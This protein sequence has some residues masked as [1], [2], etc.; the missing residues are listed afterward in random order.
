MLSGNAAPV[1]GGSA[2]AR[3]VSAVK[4]SPK[5]KLA[6]LGDKSKGFHTPDPMLRYGK[7]EPRVCHTSRST[8]VCVTS[9]HSI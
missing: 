4:A 6:S 5:F 3:D 1:T 9:R 7:G 8:T 2:A